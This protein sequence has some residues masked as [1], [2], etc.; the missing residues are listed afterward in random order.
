MFE[1]E[2]KKVPQTLDAVK[3]MSPLSRPAEVD[4]VG[5]SIVYLCSPAASY[6]F[7]VGLIVD[8]GLILTL[9]LG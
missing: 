8:A 7:G 3:A 6:V 1:G 2:C 9:H 5:N 4:E